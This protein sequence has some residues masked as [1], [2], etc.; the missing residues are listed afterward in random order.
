MKK[1]FGS[2]RGQIFVMYAVALVGLLTAVALGTDVAL[3][4]VNWQHS[5]K[6]ADAAAL[7]GANYLNGGISYADSTG[8]AYPTSSGCNGEGSDTA[9]K[10][11]CTYA[12]NNGLDASTVTISKPTAST[13][14]VVST[15]T[16]LPYFFAKV[17]GAG[18]Y[19]VSATAE[20]NSPGPVNTVTKNLVPLGLQCT[21]PC[22][23]GS[24]VAGE[25]VSFGA[26]FISSTINLPGNWGWLDLDGSGGSGLRSD[27]ASGA[28]TSYSVGSTVYTNTG[29]KVG[30]INSGLSSRFS[31]CPSIPDPCTGGGNPNNIPAGDPCLVIVPVVDFAAAAKAGKTSMP[32][33][34]FAEVYLDPKTTDAKHINGCYVTSTVGD[35]IAGPTPSSGPVAAPV[36][37]Q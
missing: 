7:A 34:Q 37:I 18:T 36:L 2:S 9:S 1:L 35:T 25:P 23:A 14:K 15:Q 22:P 32:I 20:A 10:V 33:E 13:I 3:M 6:V 4:Y 30:P 11:A 26:K 27:L 31:G 5:Q 17:S 24:F 21:T 12:V 8:T 19:T 16:G 29:A 28:S